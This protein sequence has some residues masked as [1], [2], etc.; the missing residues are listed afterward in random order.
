MRGYQNIFTLDPT[1]SA[2]FIYDVTKIL[3]TSG[4][5]EITQMTPLK[6]VLF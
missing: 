2:T 1:T 3:L 5:P 6:K 4:Q